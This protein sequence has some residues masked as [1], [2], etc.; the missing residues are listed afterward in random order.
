MELS[1]TDSRIL[2]ELLRETE[3][4]AHAAI[5]TKDV[6]MYRARANALRKVLCISDTQHTSTRAIAMHDKF[7]AYYRVSTQ[8][9][10]RSGLGLEAQQQVVMDYLSPLH[11]AP[12]TQARAR[13]PA[14]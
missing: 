11:P 2:T 8:R 4:Q 9:Q 12:S 10:G 3:R 13:S 1:A 14:P 6:I 5:R 7:I